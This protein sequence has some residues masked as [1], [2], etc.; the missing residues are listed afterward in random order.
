[1]DKLIDIRNIRTL[2][3]LDNIQF[4]FHED[5]KMLSSNLKDVVLKIIKENPN[6]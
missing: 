2:Q 6:V 5:G 4:V 1:M 3:K